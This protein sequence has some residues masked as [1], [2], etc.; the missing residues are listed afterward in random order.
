MSV[1][2]NFWLPTK[3]EES[4]IKTIESIQKQNYPYCKTT[5]GTDSEEGHDKVEDILKQLKPKNILHYKFPEKVTNGRPELLSAAAVYSTKYDLWQPVG[6]GDWFEY[7]HASAV[8]KTYLDKKPQWVFTLRNIWDKDGNFICKDIFESIGFHE[9][10]CN[11]GYFF[12]DGQSWCIPRAMAYNIANSFVMS[13]ELNQRTDKFI[14]DVYKK[15][16]PNFACTNDYTLN[17]RLNR[18]TDEQLEYAKQW[19]LNGFK[20]MQKKY[21][22]G[23]YPWIK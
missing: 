15:H 7:W 13:R 17:F 19:Y 6:S 2:I 12:V 11:P 14:F 23:N 22:D 21:P 20:H 16:Y 10:W 4:I 9:V 5:I 3:G 18:G 8:I 1:V